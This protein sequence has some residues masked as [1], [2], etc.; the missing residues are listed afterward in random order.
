MLGVGLRLG[1][2]HP[3][4]SSGSGAGA[5]SGP[6]MHQLAADVAN[7]DSSTYSTPFTIPVAANTTYFIKC[8]I[9]A[10]AAAT[11]TGQTILVSGPSGATGYAVLIGNHETATNP[12]GAALGATIT[13][14]ASPG[15]TE[16]ANVLYIRVAN[17]STAGNVT[18][19][20]KTEINASAFTWKAGTTAIV[21]DASTGVMSLAASD[22]T[23]TSATNYETLASILVP[24]NSVY[25]IEGAYAS[26]TA[27]VGVAC[28]VKMELDGAT[29][30]MILQGPTNGAAT[31]YLASRVDNSAIN[32]GTCGL[33]YQGGRYVALIV[34]GES[35]STVTIQVRSET[36]STAITVEA[37]AFAFARDVSDTYQRTAMDAANSTDTPAT[38]FSYV[39]G[40]SKHYS[41]TQ[42]VIF[43]TSATGVGMTHHWE[44][45][46]EAAADEDL[47][48]GDWYHAGANT[49]TLRAVLRD[50]T[51][52]T[53]TDSISTTAGQA[54][55]ADA[56]VNT[57]GTGGTGLFKYVRDSG[58][59]VTL[60]TGSFAVLEEVTLAA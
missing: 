55:M 3:Q 47:A 19:Q 58:T 1:L 7:S 18:I 59:S 24:A 29:G 25:L 38:G 52:T 45:M 42:A 49:T 13:T 40:A 6:T 21:F 48:I 31:Y 53:P 16:D 5:A 9:F 57:D 17:G 32:P 2:S 44:A 39:M 12:S 33:A 46:A 54:M 26:K 20:F 56:V 11:T 43:V 30:S 60:K 15:A 10:T 22:V 34:T 37:G 8:P 4:G 23:T 27:S 41:I 35:A 14:L 36:E 50:A 51:T 28:V